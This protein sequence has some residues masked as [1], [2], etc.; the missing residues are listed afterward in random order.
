M[1]MRKLRMWMVVMATMIMRMM[2]MMIMMMMMMRIMRR[3][4]RMM[5]WM[6]MMLR[7]FYSDEAE[8]DRCLIVNICIQRIIN[9]RAGE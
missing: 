5:I 2:R 4:M 9:C 7:G 1:V 8:A 6:V 3:M